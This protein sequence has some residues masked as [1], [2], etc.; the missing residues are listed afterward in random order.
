MAWPKHRFTT[1]QPQFSTLRTVQQ[2]MNY[3]EVVVAEAEHACLVSMMTTY[4][5]QYLRQ[6]SLHGMQLS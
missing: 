2:I 6:G 3:E 1:H 4:L 5:A